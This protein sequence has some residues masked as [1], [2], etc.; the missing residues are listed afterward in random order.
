VTTC[1]P[2]KEDLPGPE[3]PATEWISRG[4]E[5]LFYDLERC[6]RREEFDFDVVI[7]GSGYGGSVAAAKLAGARQE[8][9]SAPISVCVLE[10]GREHLPGMFPSRMSELA[11]HVRF[12]TSGGSA[13]RG[14]REGVFDFRLGPYMNALVGNGLG[15]GSLIN[16]G[17]M[18]R[19]AAQVFSPPWPRAIRGN[20]L[21]GYFD[22]ALGLLQAERFENSDAKPAKYEALRTL[23]PA[24]FHAAHVTVALHPRDRG[25]PQCGVEAKPSSSGVKM[26]VCKRCGD[27][28]SGCNHGSKGSLDTSLLVAARVAGAHIYTGATVL[29]VRIAPKGWEIVVT[30]TD[31]KLRTRHGAPFRL[32]ARRV[33]LAAGAFG[34]TEILLRSRKAGLELSNVLGGRFSGNGDFIASGYRQR[35][36]VR[37]GSREDVEPCDRNVGPTITG[38]VDLRDPGAATGFV[39]EDLG[40]PAPFRGLL[41]ETL[42]TFNSLHE[43]A[44][45]DR[46]EH[47]AGWPLQDPLAVDQDAIEHS[48]VLAVMGHDGS[49]GLLR[50]ID[51]VAGQDDGDGA[52]SVDWPGALSNPLYDDELEA[53]EKI[54]DGH[55]QAEG[56]VIPNPLW[57]PV[58]KELDGLFGGQR[59]P[60]AT[61][62][63]LGGCPMADSIAEGV[64][65]EFGRVFRP[66]ATDPRFVHEGLVV[67]D[68]SI[69]P[70]SLGINPSLTITALSLRAVDGLMGQWRLSAPDAPQVIERTR[71]FFRKP[72]TKHPAPTTFQLLERQTGRVQLQYGR[73]KVPRIVELTLAFRESPL[74]ALMNGSP[75]I[76]ELESGTV[77]IFEEDSWRGLCATDLDPVRDAAALDVATLTGRLEVFA[78]LPSTSGERRCRA[79]GA[80][81]ANRGK[82]DLWQAITAPEGLAGGFSP[83]MLLTLLALGTRAGE[84]RTFRYE[85]EV[86]KPTKGEFFHPGTP[87]VGLKTLTYALASNP[88]KQMSRIVLESFPRVDKH[89]MLEVDMPY[90]AAKGVPLLKIVKQEDQPAA[91]AEFGSLALYFLRMMMHIHVWSFRKP[92]DP[93]SRVPQRLPGRVLG[94]DPVVHELEVAPPGKPSVKA[95]LSHYPNNGTRRPPV[96]LIHGYSASGTTF[97]HPRLSPNLAGSLLEG[98]RDVWVLDLRTSCGMP[99]CRQPWS[100]ED[101]ARADIPVAIRHV[102]EQTRRPQVDI[103]AHCMSAAMF[104]I[105]I[106]DDVKPDDPFLAARKGLHKVIRRVVLSQVGPAVVMSTTNTLRGYIMQYLRYF[107]PL[108][109]FEFRPENP[110]LLDQ[111]LDRALS[112]LP[113]PD[114]EWSVENPPRFW[115]T[116]SFTG[117]RHRMDAL[118]GRVMNAERMPKEILEHI[119]DLFGPINLDTLAQPMQFARLHRVT[120]RCGGGNWYRGPQFRERFSMPVLS[121][122]ARESGVTD[123][124]S[125]R[126]M[127]ALFRELWGPHPHL[128]QDAVAGG[129]QDQLIGKERA[130]YF[131]KIREFLDAEDL[132]VP[133]HHALTARLGTVV[134]STVQMPESVRKVNPAPGEPPSACLIPFEIAGNT[135]GVIFL[136]VIATGAYIDVPGPGNSSLGQR[137]DAESEYVDIDRK[138]GQPVTVA[139]PTKPLE[140][141]EAW[142]VLQVT[143]GPRTRSYNPEVISPETL[144]RMLPASQVDSPMLDAQSSG[145]PGG[146]ALP[147]DLKSQVNQLIIAAAYWHDTFEPC[148]LYP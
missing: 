24:K 119:D 53:L 90:F 130:Q 16:A 143:D 1:E 17:V 106:L 126:A 64:V 8:G 80:W 70:T 49:D 60:A 46:S 124:A 26:N 116:A 111:F 69:V 118:L 5:C 43:L 110:G 30:Y 14:V 63:P 141:D 71:P 15:G 88:W 37:P 138:A 83:S 73:N 32:R 103:V 109:P 21:D 97:T 75:R 54:H 27:C 136:R 13:P 65:D 89:S 92:D 125:M 34:S 146:D 82:R 20:A 78:R 42:T 2:L 113:Y 95:R 6:E 76:L 132:P 98:G 144:G 107:F 140:P 81:W 68:G 131:A 147:P 45:C 9:R 79:L 40:I 101:V 86:V 133:A 96:I 128:D 11:G 19:P 85:L 129:H 3:G 100:F 31:D 48:S 33:I 99:T 67:L 145:S 58:P 62:H 77:R 108:M 87:I 84:A 139:I 134:L 50:L 12:S 25:G 122:H 115:E 117:T 36:V 29:E 41:E 7:V 35:E 59:G 39:V 55:L 47:K 22:E 112:T 23:A 44:H 61:V 10:R 148:L 57:K 38:F 127:Y 137:I 56:R 142:L 28:A 105:A 72:V 51:P 94:C 114:A 93:P 135:T 52:V 123:F 102:I 74:A 120:D 91:M 66:H 4:I 121:L 104:S 18:E